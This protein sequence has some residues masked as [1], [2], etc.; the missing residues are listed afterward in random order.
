MNAEFLAV[1]DHLTREKGIDREAIIQ[2]VESAL[3]SAARKSLGEQAGE[4][5]VT[6]DRATGVIY[7]A[8][9]E[10]E[11]RSAEFGRIAAQT[12][13]QVIIQKIREAERDVVY[14]EFQGKVGQLLT[15]TVQRFEGGGLVV[16]IGRTE[17]F[18]P[19]REQSPK[20]SYRHGDRIKAYLLEVK[21]SVKGP[22]ITLSRAH[23]GLVKKLFELEVPEIADGI[24]EVKSISREAGDRAKLAVI[25]KDDKVDCVGACVG[26]RGQRVKNIVRELQGE[27]IDIVRWSDKL[28]EFVVG[29]LAPAKVSKLKLDR[30]KR[31]VEVIVEDDQ[32][33]L[34]I[35]KKGQ[36]VRLAAKLT[37]LD[38][39]IRSESQIKA[40]AGIV[41]TEIPGVGPK[42]AE[43]L[44]TAGFSTVDRVAHA[45]LEEL[46]AAPGIGE[47]TAQKVFD[48]AKALLDEVEKKA[49][50]AQAVA[51]QAAEGEGVLPVPAPSA[52]EPP[53]PDAA[54]EPPP[55]EG[56]GTA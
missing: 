46:M 29:A 15:G 21:R 51:Q 16:E 30:P 25:S 19:K 7:M 18:L 41:L 38:I 52:G 17:A 23:A 9:G 12:A 55:A 54:A 43:A 39:D 53:A 27:K 37:G 42:I 11:I 49:A 32:L 28:E 50:A 4:I 47:K 8:A 31:R 22:Q 3:A 14:A 1:L 10:Q 2:A 48:G 6:I 44:Q 35:G 34:A 20:E 24:V 26:M 45:S 13:K 33:S 56:T 36:N 40:R 5:T